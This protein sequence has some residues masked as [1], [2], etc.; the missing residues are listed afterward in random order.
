MRKHPTKEEQGPGCI[1]S[2]GETTEGFGRSD[3]FTCTELPLA[4]CWEPAWQGRFQGETTVGEAGKRKG[5]Q[6]GKDE[7]LPSGAVHHSQGQGGPQ[8]ESSRQ[9]LPAGQVELRPWLPSVSPHL[10]PSQA[11]RSPPG[12]PLLPGGRRR[13]WPW[14]REPPTWRGDLLHAGPL[15]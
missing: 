3:L 14:P 1:H 12:K 11:S 5:S 2:S 8:R 10:P 4:A 13:C 15:L 7:Q 9:G 6:G